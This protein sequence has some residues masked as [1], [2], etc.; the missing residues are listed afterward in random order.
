MQGY[1]PTVEPDAAQIINI[2]EQ[3]KGLSPTAQ[4]SKK[5]YLSYLNSKAGGRIPESLIDF[6]YAAIGQPLDAL[7]TTHEFATGYCTAVQLI[8]DQIDKLKAKAQVSLNEAKQYKRQSLESTLP[9]PS[10]DDDTLLKVEV[11][12]ATGLRRGDDGSVPSPFVS[13]ICEGSSHKTSTKQMTT[14]PIWGESVNFKVRQS[15]SRLVLVVTDQDAPISRNI[16]G[17]V[18]YPLDQLKDQR[19]RVVHLTILSRDTQEEAGVLTVTFY[20]SISKELIAEERAQ[21]AKEKFS[22]DRDQICSLK[23]KLNLLHLPFS[24]L[25]PYYDLAT[26]EH[27]Q[28]KSSELSLFGGLD[29]LSLAHTGRKL[30]WRGVMMICISIA[31][32]LSC[33]TMFIRPDFP[34]LMLALVLWMWYIDDLSSHKNFKYMSIVLIASLAYDLVWFYYFFTVS[35]MQP[36]VEGSYEADL[37]RELLRASMWISLGN[38]CFKVILAPVSWRFGLD[39]QAQEC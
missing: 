31:M 19:K 16:I 33:L 38:F 34:N 28:I 8:Q 5:D 18:T 29:Q 4:L 24:S 21:Q 20:W 17:E 25:G 9:T 23:L 32:C 3:L 37:E 14:E 7:L 12:K 27:P 22:I 39:V 26:L 30:P 35:P 10:E 11:M 6:I 2:A 1:R 36:W 13:L 15:S